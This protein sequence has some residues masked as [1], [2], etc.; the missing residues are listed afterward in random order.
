MTLSE[1][2]N[3]KEP[4]PEPQERREEER[5]FQPA[6]IRRMQEKGLPD[7]DHTSELKAA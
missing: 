5:P 1:R 7:V 3:H 2:I 4:E 6:W